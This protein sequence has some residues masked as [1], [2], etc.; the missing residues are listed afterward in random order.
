[1]TGQDAPARRI[2]WGHLALV[3]VLA[4]G[5]L[6]YLMEARAVSLSP[7]NLLLLQPTAI[8]VLVLW[9]VIAWGCF[10]RPTGGPQDGPD[11]TWAARLK[12]GAMVGAFALYVAGLETVGYDVAAWAFVLAGLAIGGERRP[13][14][15]LLFPPAFAAGVILAFKAMIPYPLTT[16]IL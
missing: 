14:M 11:G 3:T 16:A 12:V 6:A 5:V 1:M 8:L 15:L 9:A 2:A 13:L 10:R 7:H 4:G